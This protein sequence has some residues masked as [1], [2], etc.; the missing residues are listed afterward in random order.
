M[1]IDFRANGD[2]FG[3]FSTTMTQDGQSVNMTGDCGTNAEMS[4]DIANGMAFAFSNWAT[5]DSWLWG[6]KCWGSC[7][8]N[9]FLTINNFVFTTGGVS[10]DPPIHDYTYGDACASKSDDY[11]DGS[12][13][14]RW[15]WPT[16]DPAQWAS[17][18]AACRCKA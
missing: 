4:Y 3:A 5:D 2:Q 16:D 13:D 15:S 6:D 7:P 18:D 9:P 8:G 14:C 1:K 11:C 10:P 17:P 12:C